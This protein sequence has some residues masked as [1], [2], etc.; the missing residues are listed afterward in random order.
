[1][2]SLRFTAVGI[3]V[4]LVGAILVGGL[5]GALLHGVP[6]HDPLALGGVAVTL[7]FVAITAGLHPAGK[8][9]SV[10]PAVL[11]KED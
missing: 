1:M 9:L 8:A 6:P 7:L 4:G 5:V 3:G 2:G 11:L 10:Q